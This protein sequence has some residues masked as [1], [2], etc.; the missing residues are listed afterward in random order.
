[1]TAACKKTCYNYQLSIS[2]SPPSSKKIRMPYSFDIAQQ[3]HF[4]SNPLQ[5]GP[6][7]FLTPRKCGLFGVSCEG[8]QKQVNFLNDEGMSSGKG[9]NE[10]ISYVHHFFTHF[11][12]GET[13]VDLHCDNF[14]GQDKNNFM[15]WYGTWW[16]AH[17]LH[18]TLNIHFLIAGHTIFAPDVGI[19]K[20]AYKRTRVSTLADIAK[21]FCLQVVENSSPES[22]LN[23]PQLVGLEDGTPESLLPKA[24][25]D[26]ELS[27]LQL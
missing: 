12:V 18:S 26:Q 13:D 7:Y 2:P 17:K 10:V 16:V 3:M 19:I 25:T 15:L 22:R 27:T 6:M 20:Q 9:S 23:I 14:T 24:P 5:P 21:S 4:L 1:M 11:G 8:L